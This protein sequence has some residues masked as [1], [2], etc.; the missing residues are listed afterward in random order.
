MSATWTSPAWK[1]P[2]ATTSPTLRPWNVTV[3]A[4]ATAAPA[5]S[6]V[7]ASTP[8]G[9]S[10]ANTGAAAAFIRAISAAASSRGSPAKPVP[11][12]ASTIASPSPS[13]VSPAFASTIRTARP[14]ASR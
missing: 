6:P 11:K 2:G 5:T 7:E 10:I 14:A 4:A 12:S 9:R 3:A 13:S 1:R 8:E